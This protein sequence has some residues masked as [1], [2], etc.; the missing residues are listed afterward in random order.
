MSDTQKQLNDMFGHM[1][2]RMQAILDAEAASEEIDG[3]DAT[4]ALYEFG[5]GVD[6]KI[7][8][9]ITLAGG[10][11]SAWLD[12]EC[13]KDDY[14]Q[15]ELDRVTYHATWWGDRPDNRQLDSSDALYQYAERIIEGMEA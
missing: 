12:C 4:D 14:G 15:L 8:V 3:Q 11:P 7:L 1:E 13:S 10:G 6:R 9:T 5:Y 2:E